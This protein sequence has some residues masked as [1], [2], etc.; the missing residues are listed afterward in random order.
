M[1][2]QVDASP[3]I[4]LCEPFACQVRSVGNTAVLGETAL[5]EAFNLKAAIDFQVRKGGGIPGYG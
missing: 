2:A 1:A 4:V 3:S 5:V